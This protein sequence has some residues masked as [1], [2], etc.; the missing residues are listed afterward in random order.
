MYAKIVNWPLELTKEA[1]RTEAL[2][3]GK[4]ANNPVALHRERFRDVRVSRHFVWNI[5]HSFGQASDPERNPGLAGSFGKASKYFAVELAQSSG[6]RSCQPETSCI[7]V[8]RFH[9]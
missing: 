9:Q 8:G 4:P 6:F 1:E 5:R 7:C 2:F 3:S